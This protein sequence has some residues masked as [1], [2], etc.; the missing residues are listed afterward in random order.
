MGGTGA[1]ISGARGHV[2]EGQILVARANRGNEAKSAG[3][4]VVCRRICVEGIELELN[5]AR[6]VFQPRNLGIDCVLDH[7]EMQ[8]PKA[9][10][11][12]VDH[13]PRDVLL[14]HAAKCF[15]QRGRSGDQW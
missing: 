4:V 9:L 2:G 10:D 6:N 1:D 3:K 13:K 7:G 5:A 14:D 8:Q 15:L 11:P 12:S